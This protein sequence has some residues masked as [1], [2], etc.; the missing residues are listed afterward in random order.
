MAQELEKVI[1]LCSR[2]K[3]GF[4]KGFFFPHSV[5]SAAIN[6]WDPALPDIV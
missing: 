3:S 2:E 6:M 5:H 4:G 1:I